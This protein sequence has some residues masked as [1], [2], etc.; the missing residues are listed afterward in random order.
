MA[1]QYLPNE[2]DYA[3]L[4]RTERPNLTCL[5]RLFSFFGFCI[6]VSFISC[7][8]EAI[9]GNVIPAAKACH[10][11]AAKDVCVTQIALSRPG[12]SP[13]KMRQAYLGAITFALSRGRA[14]LETQHTVQAPGRRPQRA[15]RRRSLAMPGPFAA[16]DEFLPT[17]GAHALCPHGCMHQSS[18]S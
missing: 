9:S 12:L 15:I 3:G 4:D 2:G 7:Q 14:P 6:V 13:G 18:A 8:H 17:L 10:M 11:V 1:I 16:R 5:N